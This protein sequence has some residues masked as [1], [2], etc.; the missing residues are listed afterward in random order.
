MLTTQS[1]IAVPAE[2][3]DLSIIRR[4]QRQF[5]AYCRRCQ[6][7]VTTFTAAQLK[8]WRIAIEE[9]NIHLIES[10]QGTLVCGQ[11]LDGKY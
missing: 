4:Q 6:K 10:G 11:S 2:S 3:H 9:G 7:D 5:S 1:Q 8:A